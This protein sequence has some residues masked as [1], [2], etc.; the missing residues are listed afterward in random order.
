[1]LVLT[2]LAINVVGDGIR[3]AL[4]PRAQIRIKS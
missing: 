3:D 2:V 1:M 4:D